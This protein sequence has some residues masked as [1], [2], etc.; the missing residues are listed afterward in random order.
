MP[1]DLSA[2]PAAPE[3][4]PTLAE[5]GITWLGDFVV[6]DLP[7]RVATAHGEMLALPYSVEL[8]DIPVVMVQHHDE[9]EL[10]RRARL[11]A[12]R[13]IAEAVASAG[14]NIMSIAIHPY[15]SAVPHRI[16]A[17]A[18]LFAELA[19][20]PR[21]A[22]MQGDEIAVWYRASGDGA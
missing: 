17:L 2:L 4:R 19:A 18:A 9:K 11:Q 10:P 14:V 15:I 13:L 20:D 6:D 3:T 22:F 5:A 12:K 7:A 21:V 1:L 8:N 16:D